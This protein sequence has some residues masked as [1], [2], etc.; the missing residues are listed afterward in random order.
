MPTYRE[1]TRDEGTRGPG[2]IS[3]VRIFP[4]EPRRKSL[5]SNSSLASSPTRTHTEPSAAQPGRVPGSPTQRGRGQRAGAS[6][7]GAPGPDGASGRGSRD[8]RPGWVGP[9]EWFPLSFPPSLHR[10]ALGGSAARPLRAGLVRGAAGGRGAEPGRPGLVGAGPGPREGPGRPSL[11]PRRGPSGRAGR[12]R[13]DGSLLGDP[14]VAA[15]IQNGHPASR[16]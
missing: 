13:W 14:R 16:C 1:W 3:P 12:C 15:S 6:P 5:K 2:K 4:Q 7:S 10:R 8:V 9:S 11:R